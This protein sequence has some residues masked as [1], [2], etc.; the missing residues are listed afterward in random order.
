MYEGVYNELYNGVEVWVYKKSY[1]RGSF[2]ENNFIWEVS[3]VCRIEVGNL[4]RVVWNRNRYEYLW[5][6]VLIVIYSVK[7]LIYG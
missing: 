2:I 7:Y 6:G 1:I 3:I 4:W 5:L